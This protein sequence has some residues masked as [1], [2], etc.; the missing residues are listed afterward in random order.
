MEVL[1]FKLEEGNIVVNDLPNQKLFKALKV[2][3]KFKQLLS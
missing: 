2:I 3:I 1:I